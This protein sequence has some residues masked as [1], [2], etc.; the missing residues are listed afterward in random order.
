M[1]TLPQGSVRLTS[2]EQVFSQLDNPAANAGFSFPGYK[3]RDVL[4]PAFHMSR[5]ILHRLKY[6]YK[7]Y[8]PPCLLAFRGH[9][10]PVDDLKVRP[11]WIQPFET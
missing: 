9:L 1:E 11:I 8:Q 7:V 3:K 2:F 10:S 5:N 4:E 6:G